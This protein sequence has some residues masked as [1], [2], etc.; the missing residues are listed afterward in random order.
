MFLLILSVL[1]W[2]YFVVCLKTKLKNKKLFLCV[3]VV[4][5]FFVDSKTL[6]FHSKDRC[7]LSF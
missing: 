1:F 5:C 3:C 2:F 4:C 7:F 6:L